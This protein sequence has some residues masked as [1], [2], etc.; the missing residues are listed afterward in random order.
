[1]SRLFREAWF[2]LRGT[3]ER[4]KGLCVSCL[5]AGGRGNH[6]RLTGGRLHRNRARARTRSLC[7]TSLAC[8][9]DDGDQVDGATVHALQSAALAASAVQVLMQQ[10]RGRLPSVRNGLDSSLQARPELSQRQRPARVHHKSALMVRWRR[11]P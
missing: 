1:V 10:T 9:Q 6:P 11:P 5:V 4:E 2:S 8:W 7:K 3:L